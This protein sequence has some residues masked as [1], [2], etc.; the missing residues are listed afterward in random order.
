MPADPAAMPADPAD[1]DRHASALATGG[2]LRSPAGPPVRGGVP[3]GAG[4][5]GRAER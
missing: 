1:Y 2:Y 3:G 4:K 5:A